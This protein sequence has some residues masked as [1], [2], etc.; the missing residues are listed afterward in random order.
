MRMHICAAGGVVSDDAPVNTGGGSCSCYCP[1]DQG[2]GQC[3]NVDSQDQCGDV[4]SQATMCPAV[5]AP[6]LSVAMATAAGMVLM[7]LPVLAAMLTLYCDRA[8]AM[9]TGVTK[10]CTPTAKGS[11]S[12]GGPSKR[13]SVF[14]ARTLYAIEQCKSALSRR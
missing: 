1:P 8:C 3:F 11:G 14:A 12:S 10:Q 2:F 13:V 6:V 7:T 5:G 4:A 9:H